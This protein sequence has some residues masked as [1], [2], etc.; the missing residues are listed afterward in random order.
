MI[1]YTGKWFKNN[2]YDSEINMLDLSENLSFK[3]QQLIWLIKDNNTKIQDLTKLFEEIA[4]G[5]EDNAASIEEISASIQELSS[6]SEVISNKTHS[7]EKVC[8]EALSSAK[9]NKKWMMIITH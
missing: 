5:A 3:T 2:G 7:L 4:S 8:D 1:F 9:K 6:S